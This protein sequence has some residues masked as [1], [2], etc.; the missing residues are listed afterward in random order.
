MHSR[1]RRAGFSLLELMI[2]I[3]II[4][5]LFAIGVVGFLSIRR[6]SNEK[7]TGASLKSLTTAEE[8]FKNNDLDQN[9]ISDY[10][11]GD[12]S[13]LY[14][15]RVIGSTGKSIMALNDIGLA[16]ADTDALAAG[17]YTNGTVE[18]TG[19]PM[20]AQP[21]SG[22][23]YQAMVRDEQGADLRVDTDG[24]GAVHN[25]GAHGFCAVP[26]N[27]GITGSYCYIISSG[28]AVFR[29]DLAA[30]TPSVTVPA[31]RFTT[32]E[33]DQFPAGPTLAASWSKAE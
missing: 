29:I 9:R 27:Y 13:G 10:W 19:I 22:Y 33:L 2:V 5:V 16:S 18:H 25:N 17:G 12:V 7:A 14:A 30:L 8:S 21:K 23:W 3:S 4:A 20:A 1:N 31:A 28:N 15:I 6:A 32:P 11:T 26:A 24:F